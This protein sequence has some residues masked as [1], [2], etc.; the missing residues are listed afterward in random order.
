[1]ANAAWYPCTGYPFDGGV[2]AQYYFNDTA[3]VIN[4]KQTY[5]ESGEHHVKIGSANISGGANPA[6]TFSLPTQV[7]V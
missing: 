1:M 3:A 2:E 5:V 7:V 4:V 6:E